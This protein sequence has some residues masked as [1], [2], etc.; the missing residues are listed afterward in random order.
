M[1]VGVQICTQLQ[2]AG[3]QVYALANEAQDSF[4]VTWTLNYTKLIMASAGHTACWDTMV[5]A[6]TDYNITWLNIQ[7]HI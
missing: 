7:V 4:I 2:V 3:Q 5:D 1:Y 6:V